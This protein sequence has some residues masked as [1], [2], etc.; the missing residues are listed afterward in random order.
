MVRLRR[1]LSPGTALAGL[2]F[3]LG[4]CAVPLGPRYTIEK[5]SLDAHFVAQP[6]PHLEIRASYRL[7]NTGNQTL[8]SILI[9]LPNRQFYDVS[10]FHARLDGK[11]VANQSLIGKASETSQITFESY[12]AKKQPH[13][14]ILSYDCSRGITLQALTLF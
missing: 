8:H 5:K 6:Q 2:L 13:E 1:R 14:L 3:L 12:S 4:S 10:N 7:V 11:E 9:R